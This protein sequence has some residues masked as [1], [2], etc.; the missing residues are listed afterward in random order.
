MIQGARQL[1]VAATKDWHGGEDEM[2]PRFLEPMRLAFEQKQKQRDLEIARAETISAYGRAAGLMVAIGTFVLGAALYALGAYVAA[3]LSVTAW[4]VA[5]PLVV[6]AIAG[7][8]ISYPAKAVR[9]YLKSTENE[10]ALREA[11]QIAVDASNEKQR[12]LDE[13]IKVIEPVAEIPKP[14]TEKLAEERVA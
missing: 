3:L 1:S 9:A 10:S 8:V 12:Q 13:G 7:F 4:W 5:V 6:V 11:V 2:N 14:P